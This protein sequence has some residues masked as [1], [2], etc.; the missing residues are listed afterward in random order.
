MMKLDDVRK[1]FQ[2]R[3]QVLTSKVSEIDHTLREPDSADWEE[4]AVENEDDE[5]L[6]DMGNAAL[7]EIVQINAA[8]QRLDM[9][10]FG[11]CTSCGEHID[12]QRLDALPYAPNCLN[13]AKEAEASV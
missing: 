11:K 8:V 9:G 5:V 3:L 12:D 13:C 4:R 1:Q 2:A 10:T 6:E 7:E